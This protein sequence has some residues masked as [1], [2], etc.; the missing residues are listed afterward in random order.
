MASRYPA[1][2]HRFTVR[3]LF[4]ARAAACAIDSRVPWR[5]M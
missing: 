4:P 3:V 5:S 2:I 1:L